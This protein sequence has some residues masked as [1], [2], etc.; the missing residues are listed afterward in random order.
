[1]NASPSGSV[2]ASVI[3]TAVACSVAALT[4]LQVGAWLTTV[5]ATACGADVAPWPSSATTENPSA[6]LNP[7]SGV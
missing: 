1:V 3:A 5:I 4:A 2:H 7:C 6:P